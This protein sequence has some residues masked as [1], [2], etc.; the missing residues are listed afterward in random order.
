MNPAIQAASVAAWNDEAH[1][2]E[3]RRLYAE[4]FTR[5]I[6]ILKP[7]LPVT[8]PDAR[9]LSLVN[10]SAAGYAR[11]LRHRLRAGLYPRL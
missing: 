4:K 1:V 2:A 11:N 7:V 10:L 8:L 3:N 9:F 6:E 5:V